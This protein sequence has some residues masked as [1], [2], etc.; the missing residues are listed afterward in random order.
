MKNSEIKKISL[1]NAGIITGATYF[2]IHTKD[3]CTVYTKTGSYLTDST[4]L[5]SIQFPPKFTIVSFHNGKGDLVL[6]E[7]GTGITESNIES[8]AEK[9]IDPTA[10]NEIKR[11]VI[12]KGF[13]CFFNK[14]GCIVSHYQR[15]DIDGELSIKNIQ[16]AFKEADDMDLINLCEIGD[17]TSFSSMIINACTD[18][19][20]LQ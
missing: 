7:N 5:P 14:N 17:V 16:E 19:C 10:K 15:V 20:I 8:Y 3:A 4:E 6:L 9:R 13:V 12:G 1:E 11:A 2:K 18:L